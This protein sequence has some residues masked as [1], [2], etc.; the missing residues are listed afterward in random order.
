[1]LRELKHR[2]R[3][4]SQQEVNGKVETI[5]EDQLES[6]IPEIERDLAAA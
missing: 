6:F 5:R 1:M 4:A 3:D 2:L